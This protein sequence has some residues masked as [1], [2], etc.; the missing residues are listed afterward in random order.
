[1]EAKNLRIGNLIEAEGK[2]MQN[3]FLIALIIQII[4]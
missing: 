4:F 2:I 3:L 1:M